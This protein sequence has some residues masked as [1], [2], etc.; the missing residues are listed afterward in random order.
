[1]CLGEEFMKKCYP[2]ISRTQNTPA[3]ASLIT[4]LCRFPSIA[5]GHGNT[6]DEGIRGPWV[7]EQHGGGRLGSIFCMWG[8]PSQASRFK[9]GGP[10]TNVLKISTGLG[11]KNRLQRNE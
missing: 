10:S 5:V 11:S 3:C 8:S 4:P 9:T 2:F 7:S 6:L 1:M